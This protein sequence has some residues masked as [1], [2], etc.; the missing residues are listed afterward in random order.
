HLALPQVGRLAHDPLADQDVADAVDNLVLGP[1]AAV[2]GRVRAVPESAVGIVGLNAGHPVRIFFSSLRRHTSWPRDWSSDV[3]SSDLPSAAALS[4][5]A[6][7]IVPETGES[8]LRSTSPLS[9]PGAPS[10]VMPTP[11]LR[12]MTISGP[13][14]ASMLTNPP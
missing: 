14:R 1:G 7:V 13:W 3:C 12:R 2:A 10:T 5:A 11:P 9:P 8:V 4:C 6:T